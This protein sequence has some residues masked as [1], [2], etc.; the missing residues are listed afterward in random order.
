MR[1][2]WWDPYRIE[3]EGE[4]LNKNNNNYL[5]VASTI[6][7]RKMFEDYTAFQKA[8]RELLWGPPLPQILIEIHISSWEVQ[9]LFK[10]RYKFK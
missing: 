7:A 5:H 8:A 1:V 10:H 9:L 2:L 6:P 3:E 4:R